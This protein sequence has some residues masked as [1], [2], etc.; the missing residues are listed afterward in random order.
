MGRRFKKWHE[1]KNNVYKFKSGTFS[2]VNNRK[3]LMTTTNEKISPL[4]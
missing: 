2:L 3:Y 1:N 4:V